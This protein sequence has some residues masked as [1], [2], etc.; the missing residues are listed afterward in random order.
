MLLT[1]PSAH[2]PSVYTLQAEQSRF[3]GAF[4]SPWRMRLTGL[5]LLLPT[6]FALQVEQS[7][8][9]VRPYSMGDAV[10]EPPETPRVEGPEGPTPRA[11]NRSVCKSAA[12]VGLDGIA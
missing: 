4:V 9:V 10:E 6:C 3:V 5:P 8:F 11:V 1:L 7:R 2:A 12:A